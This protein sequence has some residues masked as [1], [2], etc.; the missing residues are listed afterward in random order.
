M[1]PPGPHPAILTPEPLRQLGD[2]GVA[3][4]ARGLARSGAACRR[5]A[6]CHLTA[7]AATGAPLK[8]LALLSR[9]DP[10]S[11]FDPAAAHWA[12]ATRDLTTRKAL[13]FSKNRWFLISP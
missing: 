10:A 11:R 1:Y 13:C 6:P 5:P 7:R 3:A 12:C 8:H 4:L 2:P 9:E